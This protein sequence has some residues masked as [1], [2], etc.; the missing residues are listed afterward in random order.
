M[1]SKLNLKNF[2]VFEEVDLHFSPHLNVI[3][4]ENGTGKSHLLKLLYATAS[5]SQNM[6][7]STRT[8]K[9]EFQRVIADGLRDIFKPDSLGRLV[10]RQQGRNR[11]D[12]QVAFTK[13]TCNYSFSFASNSKT[14][15]RLE[16]I[17]TEFQT[18]NAIFFPTREM[19]SI[20]PGFAAAYRARELSFDRTYYDLALA[21]EA[22]P[23]KGRRPKEENLLQQLEQDVG[24]TVFVENSQFYLA[25]PGV[26]NF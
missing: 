13:N 10:T 14:E 21:L 16:K 11:A 23:L 7:L 2:S 24:G 8:G 12:I 15:V 6:N 9:E 17:P 26:G 4:G 20:F 18:E 1:I 3:I 25:V 22:S 5:G 19:L